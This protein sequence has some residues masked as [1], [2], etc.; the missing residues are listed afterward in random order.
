MALLP[1]MLAG[2]H[3]GGSYSAVLDEAA[4]I[5][6]FDPDSAR[7]ILSAIPS[8]SLGGEAE[9]DRLMLLSVCAGVECDDGEVLEEMAG[10]YGDGENSVLVLQAMAVRNMAQKNYPQAMRNLLRADRLAADRKDFRK[11]AWLR[12]LMKAVNDSVYNERGAQ[13]FAFRAFQAFELGGDSTEMYRVGK[14]VASQAVFSGNFDRAEEVIGKI[15]AI[16]E[17]KNDS[18]EM[19]FLS[20]LTGYLQGRKENPGTDDIGFA[21]DRDFADR[22][23]A[24]GD[25]EPLILPDSIEGLTLSGLHD[26]VVS[27][28]DAGESAKSYSLIKALIERYGDNPNRT[29]VL[30]VDG[31]KSADSY[32]LLSGR[33]FMKLFQADV[34]AEIRSFD[35][36]EKVERQRKIESQRLVI[37]LTAALLLVVVLF[38]VYLVSVRMRRQR[39]KVSE[40]LDMAEELNRNFRKAQSSLF[41]TFSRLCDVYY[42]GYVKNSGSAK[43]AREALRAIEDFSKSPD[44]FM[45]LE[46]CLDNTRSGL[47]ARFREQMP[48]LREDE[49]KLFL[50]NALGLSVPT[51]TLLLGE[52]REV[53][54]NRRLRLRSK[55]QASAPAD[56]ERF[57]ECLG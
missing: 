38:A 31:S 36:L 40:I 8:D 32:E 3:C 29:V 5:V 26:L 17:I 22:L 39:M 19:S 51:M 27:L 30:S 20:F 49:Y 33:Q 50:C 35:Y 57:V 10:R 56:C 46:D 15:G 47:M 52:K 24:L 28:W 14:D 45:E 34:D 18:A 23:R 53:V 7:I 55:I 43:G 48:G 44:F 25:N 16:A 12:L 1:A 21:L 2:C 11:A 6:D 37:V 13:E 9:R 54:Y 42:D 41:M 4:R